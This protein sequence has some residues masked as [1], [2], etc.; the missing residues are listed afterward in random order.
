MYPTPKLI[1]P[2]RLPPSPPSPSH[3]LHIMLIFYIV[4]QVYERYFA[5]NMEILTHTMTP[6][7]VTPQKVTSHKVTSPVLACH[8]KPGSATEKQH[9]RGEKVTG[10]IKP[11][12]PKLR[13]TFIIVS[14][15]LYH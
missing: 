12:N 3:N 10:L 5:F 8:E 4:M 13:F 9:G 2:T 11:K 7:K 1:R 6:H 14:Y 15:V